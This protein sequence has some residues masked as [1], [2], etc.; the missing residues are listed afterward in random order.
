MDKTIVQ[1]IQDTS[2]ETWYRIQSTIGRRQKDVL[3]A[4]RTQPNAT[5]AE[6]AHMLRWPINRVT[7]RTFELREIGV[8]E[9][10]GKRNC[11]VTGRRAIAWRAVPMPSA[12]PPEKKVDEM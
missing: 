4:L 8:V 12:F 2:L 10:I 9:E 11:R 5:N 3:D 6:I 1:M 7:P